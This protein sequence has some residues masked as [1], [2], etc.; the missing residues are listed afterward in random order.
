MQEFLGR[1]SE[2]AELRAAIDEARAG[3]GGL[4]LIAGGAAR[5][6]SEDIAD[7][8]LRR[9]PEGA[10]D[11]LETLAGLLLQDCSGG[12]QIDVRRKDAGVAQVGCQ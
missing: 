4:V 9:D 1:G 10:I 12:V 6:L 11:P 5:A 8:L 2:L 3:H 7:L